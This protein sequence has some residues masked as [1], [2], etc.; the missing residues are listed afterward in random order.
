MPDPAPAYPADLLGTRAQRMLD[1][2]PPHWSASIFFRAIL[3]A[4]GYEVDTLAGYVDDQPVLTLPAD[5][6]EW[7]IAV[8][9]ANLGIAPQDGWTLAERR[10]VIVAAL[11]PAQLP[12]EVAEYVAAQLRLDVADVTI[13][14]AGLTL[15]AQIDAA[16]S[17]A[18]EALALAS[19]ERVTPAHMTAA[20]EL[21]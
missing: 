9:E 19:L 4:E 17:A 20:V 16:L 7:A 6:P 10:R 1:Y 3:Q 14:V 12:A 15:T 18:S 2:L 8:W 21:V 11:S 5:M 13:V